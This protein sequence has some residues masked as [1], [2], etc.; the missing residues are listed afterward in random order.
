MFICLHFKNIS[1]LQ[2]KIAFEF[3]EHWFLN[4][5][6]S[7]LPTVGFE[8]SYHFRHQ[9]AFRVWFAWNC[10]Q[11]WQITCMYCVECILRRCLKHQQESTKLL[12]LTIRLTRT[13]K[14]TTTIL[15]MS[16]LLIASGM[17]ERAF[18]LCFRGNK[19]D[20][21]PPSSSW[22]SDLRSRQD[23]GRRGVRLFVPAVRCEDGDS[24]G[25]TDLRSR[26]TVEKY[27]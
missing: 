8:N 25:I 17:H 3:K 15:L 21:A 4:L 7:V 20:N 14:F 22:S 9:V 24:Y 2:K 1:K 13:N 10:I 18:C 5:Q 26:R 16:L 27:R 19:F 12:R 6:S 23:D 11:K